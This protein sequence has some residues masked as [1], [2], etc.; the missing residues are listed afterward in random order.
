MKVGDR[1]TNQQA[2]EQQECEWLVLSP[3]LYKDKAP[4]GG[5]VYAMESDRKVARKKKLEGE[6]LHGS[7]TMENRV[8]RGVSVEGVFIG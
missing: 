4:A 1:I 2:T 7:A 3:I 5:I 6:K 8:N